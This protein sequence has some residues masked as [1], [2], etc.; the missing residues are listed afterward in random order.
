MHRLRLLFI[1]LLLVAAALG[2]TPVGAQSPFYEFTLI[3]WEGLMAPVD[4]TITG[5]EANVS[6]NEEG[7]VAFIGAVTSGEP[8]VTMD[9]LFVGNADWNLSNVSQ[10]PTPR[11]FD[12]PQINNQGRV[13]TRELAGGHSVVHVWWMSNP[14]AFDT[15]ATTTTSAFSQLTMPTLG[16]TNDVLDKPLVSFLGRI[17]DLD[18]GLY[19]NDTLKPNTQDFVSPLTGTRLAGFRSATAASWARVIAAQFQGI[20]DGA[21]QAG[22]QQFAVFQDAGN[23]G[24]WDETLIASTGNG[25]PWAELGIAPGIS[26]SGQIVAFA[27]RHEAEGE[28]I[29]I[30]VSADRF[31]TP[32]TPIKVIGADT[33][34]AFD[35]QGRPIKFA[36]F[37]LSNRIAVLHD[38]WQIG[39]PDGF[40]NDVVT[41]AFVATP[42]RASMANSTSVFRPLVFNANEGL[43]TLRV[44]LEK[45]LAGP[46]AG[47][48][49]RV[50]PASPVPVI[51]SADG[52]ISL[53]DPLALA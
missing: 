18:F 4:G 45:D 29:W 7:F 35:E 31:A 33:T 12:F 20:E 2:M 39:A 21:P 40:A 6:I 27:A 1:R 8:P 13:V 22:V 48:R 28:G 5:I 44:D 11:N 52:A 37:A 38:E 23:N 16:N 15:I 30:A 46:S 47:R 32:A 42:E 49:I 43:W 3:A 26:D 25:Q 51:Q 53:Y 14:G 19:A 36:S 9:Q 50:H 34:I 10:S 41:I 24:L 17:A